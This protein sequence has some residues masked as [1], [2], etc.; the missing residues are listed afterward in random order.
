MTYEIT[1]PHIHM[2]PTLKGTEQS[3]SGRNDAGGRCGVQEK[4][5]AKF[6][7]MQKLSVPNIPNRDPEV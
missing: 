4:V 5:G 7:A 3:S 6:L 1:H 2:T